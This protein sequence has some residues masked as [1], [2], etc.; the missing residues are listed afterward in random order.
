MKGTF[1]FLLTLYTVPCYKMK[2]VDIVPQTQIPGFKEQ[3]FT[4]TPQEREAVS[5]ILTLILGKEKPI[6]FAYLFGS[7]IEDIPFH[8]LD[9]G[10][11]LEDMHKQEAISFSLRLGCVLEQAAKLPVDLRLLNHAPVSFVFHVLRGRLL[12]ERDEETHC[13]ILENT[14]REYLDIEP[15]LRIATRE[16]FG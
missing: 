7:F 10:I 3:L 2:P 5:A 11:F 15:I 14:M 13:R 1:F 9:I 4:L 16:A 6:L 8:D 12:V